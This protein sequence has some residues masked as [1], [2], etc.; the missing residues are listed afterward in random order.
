VED[1]NLHQITVPRTGIKPLN[2]M[3]TDEI[4]SIPLPGRTRTEDCND[5]V[6]GSKSGNYQYPDPGFF[7][8]VK[9]FNIFSQKIK[10]EFG[11]FKD[12]VEGNPLS[13]FSP[14]K[15]IRKM[16]IKLMLGITVPLTNPDAF[17]TFCH[18]S[19]TSKTQ[20]CDGTQSKNAVRG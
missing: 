7:R 11:S 8:H 16:T 15:K 10:H 9:Q 19:G 6:A 3:N 2:D 5:D 17:C 20:G 13:P 1:A 4:G 18:R 14:F 12:I